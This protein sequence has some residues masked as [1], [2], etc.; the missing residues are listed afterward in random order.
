LLFRWFAGVNPD[1]AVRVPTVF[2]KNRDQLIEGHIAD[3]FMQEVREA[4]DVR[5]LCRTSISPSTFV[6]KSA[7]I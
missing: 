2:R 3:A 5:A 1:D 7:R 4:A 6:A